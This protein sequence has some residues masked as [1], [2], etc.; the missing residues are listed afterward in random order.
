LVAKAGDKKKDK[1]PKTATTTI[2]KPVKKN[3]DDDN[4]MDEDAHPPVDVS[5][6]A[7]ANDKKRARKT[8]DPENAEKK[9]TQPKKPRKAAHAD[10]E[11]IDPN[12]MLANKT[13]GEMVDQLVA[14][15]SD[16]LMDVFMTLYDSI[17]ENMNI[18]PSE[19]FKKLTKKELSNVTV[20][21]LLYKKLFNADTLIP[22]LVRMSQSATLLQ[23]KQT[24]EKVKNSLLL[25]SISSCLQILAEIQRVRNDVIKVVLDEKKKKKEKTSPKNKA[26]D[27][28]KATN[29]EKES[30]KSSNGETPET[31]ATA[32]AA[33]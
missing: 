32:E 19:D 14:G 4:T 20:L 24:N 21:R 29:P 33:E 28:K 31:A 23:D 5:D 10:K 3:D 30:T 18:M 27:T 16:N 2:K 11:P 12:T 22:I 13:L 15:G 1:A 9:K 6:G 8:S 17:I 7:T 25:G 26:V